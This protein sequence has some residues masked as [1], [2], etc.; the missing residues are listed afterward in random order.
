MEAASRLLA[1]EE[2]NPGAFNLLVRT[3]GRL[4]R[5]QDAAEAQ[6]VEVSS[7]AKLILLQGFAPELTCC[8]SCG[9]ETDLVAFSPGDGGAVCGACVSSSAPQGREA[10]GECLHA[11]R[12]LLECPLGELPRD[13]LGEELVVQVGR[14]AR[15]IIR[16][17]AM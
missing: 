12:T 17:H 8:V 6:L 11:F 15:H 1:G 5:A 4:A 3:V 2:S 16:E 10:G 13:L 9:R 7:V 14:L